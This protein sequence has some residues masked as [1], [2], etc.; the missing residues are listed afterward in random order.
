MNILLDNLLNLEFLEPGDFLYCECEEKMSTFGNEHW[1]L[2]KT[3][4]VS[5][6]KFFQSEHICDII[7]DL[8]TKILLLFSI[9]KGHHI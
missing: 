7:P 3:T 2:N 5:F 9:Q 8:L 1:D 6:N 4:A